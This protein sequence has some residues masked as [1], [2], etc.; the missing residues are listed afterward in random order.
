M[1][2][3]CSR[4]LLAMATLLVL[5]LPIGAQDKRTNSTPN[6]QGGS[7]DS[8][9][10]ELVGQYFAA[11]ARKDVAAMTALWGSKSPDLET[12]RK[13]AEQFFSANDKVEVRKVT[14]QRLSVE[15]EKAHLSVGLEM[16]AVNVKTGNPSEG[17]GAMVRSIDCVKEE[18][19]WKLWRDADGDEEFAGR[20]TAISND[21]EREDLLKQD[22]DFVTPRLFRILTKQGGMLISRGDMKQAERVFQT[23][24]QVA[25]KNDDQPGIANASSGLGVIHDMQGDHRRA[26][27]YYEKALK[28]AEA[29]NDKLLIARILLNRGL[30][31]QFL[32]EYEQSLSDYTKSLEIAESL[33]DKVRMAKLYSNM[34]ELQRLQG[35]LDEAIGYYQKALGIAQADGND[36]A[37]VPMVLRNIGTIYSYKGN[38]GLAME[39]FQ[40]SLEIL[41]QSNES[42]VI[43]ALFSS[44]GEVQK[45]Q[46]DYQQALVSYQKGLALSEK[47]GDEPGIA[48]FLVNMGDAEQALG[49]NAEAMGHFQKSLALFDKLGAKD[50]TLTVLIN[51]GHLQDVQGHPEDAF[52]SY[53]KSLALAESLG[54]QRN[55][56]IAAG[57]I[58]GLYIDQ[59]KYEDALVFAQR[60]EDIARRM[61][62]RETLWQA[63]ESAGLSYRGLGEREKARGA[64]EEAIST[65]EL[66][67]SQVVGTEEQQQAYFSERHAPYVDMVE[68]LVGQNQGADALAYAERAKGRALL[69]VLRSGRVSITKAMSPEER[70]REQQLQSEMVSLNKQ[71]ERE[72]GEEKPDASRVS[73][74][75]LRIEDARLRYS[76]FQTN[77]FA[78]HPELKVQRGQIQPVSLQEAAQLLPDSRSAFLE[79]ETAKEKTYLFVL[80]R[81]VKADQ[82]VPDLAVYAI[83]FADKTLKEKAGRFNEQLSRRDLAFRTSSRELFQL[84]IKP[85]MAKL[86][87]KNALVI[88]PDGPLWNLPFQALVT[89][90]GHY[91]LEEYAV[92]YA[93][94]LTVLREM[95]RAHRQTLTGT[96]GPQSPTL[97]AMADPALGEETV[98]RATITYRSEDLGPLPEAKKEAME[99]KQLYGDK[100]SAIYTGSDAR[101]DRFKSEARKFHIL[102]LATHGVFND[103]SPMY[104]YVLLSQ[105]QADSKED[106][107]LEAWEIM[108]MDLKADLAVLS[109]CETGRGRVSAGEGL[110]GLTWAFFVAGVPTTVVSEWKVESA[111]TANLMLAFHRALRAA[112]VQPG[113]PF[114][115]AKA[116]QRAEAQLLHNQHYSHPFYWAGFVVVGDPN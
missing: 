2:R 75:K 62:V 111:S 17:L 112:D 99:L 19:L 46:G 85:A 65:I 109:A 71:I 39:Y 28:I 73:N 82:V 115:T 32:D 38:Y 53:K 18:G 103:A 9:V 41:G 26:I 64:F 23:A 61:G 95:M 7:E 97:L 86:A 44:I 96:I 56:A 59:H 108:Q 3:S 87:G 15:G 89:N 69:D 68:L 52:D 74:L 78:T 67:R 24:Q 4:L 42:R 114:A 1:L 36:K 6:S 29:T 27:E 84:L 63:L 93:P 83:P 33:Q 60:S 5:W 48:G 81:K 79:F 37:T 34:G 72:T 22:P 30:S 47:T 90:N 98:R 45:S 88:V 76:E 8:A 107:L 55:M 100:Q 51:I 35:N 58:A 105:G 31:H 101:E 11:Y 102:H 54:D 92:S 16:S 66:V 21:G 113:S 116:L 10:R 13:A 43:K 40:K 50:G 57:S 14:V 12:Q 110:I 104:S 91:L 70:E 80:T 25:T 20:L 106:G 77:L 94:S 49:H